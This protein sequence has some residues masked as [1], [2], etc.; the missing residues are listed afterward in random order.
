MLTVASNRRCWCETLQSPWE[1]SLGTQLAIM[2]AIAGP[3][4]HLSQAQV[5]QEQGIP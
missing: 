4:S 5:T 1:R 3:Q 2:Q